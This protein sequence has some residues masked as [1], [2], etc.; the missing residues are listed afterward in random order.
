MEGAPTAAESSGNRRLWG[1]HP[2]PNDSRPD[3]GVT[4]PI[5]VCVAGGLTHTG[6]DAVSLSS[7]GPI[8]A[9]RQDACFHGLLADWD[10]AGHTCFDDDGVD[11][12]DWTGN[13]LGDCDRPAIV[14]DWPAIAIGDC[15]CE[16]AC[17]IGFSPAPTGVTSKVSSS[18]CH[19]WDVFPVSPGR[20]GQ[21]GSLRIPT[22]PYVFWLLAGE[23]ARP[24]YSCV[25]V[26]AQPAHLP[27]ALPP[28]SGVCVASQVGAPAG[29]GESM[30]PVPA[31]MW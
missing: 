2:A 14:D 31:S 19:G 4:L 3:I 7:R 26:P 20:M 25:S 21:P 23:P 29:D 5:C 27:T 13:A 8:V 18:V 11:G 9:E 22:P 30:Y 6:A 15:D 17:G 10:T 28:P 24:F 1:A 16:G 12:R